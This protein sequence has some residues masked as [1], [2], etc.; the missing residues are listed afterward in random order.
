[1]A[2]GYLIL[3]V[4]CV[5]AG[6]MFGVGSVLREIVKSNHMGQEDTSMIRKDSKIIMYTLLDDGRG[7]S[8][9]NII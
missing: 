5:M 7:Y 1:M 2:L 4:C 9:G 8:K 6:I 3:T